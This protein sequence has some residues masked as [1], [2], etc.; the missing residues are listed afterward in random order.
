MTDKKIGVKNIEPTLF[1]AFM[2]LIF[3]IALL[4]I[5]VWIFGS[6]SLDGSNQMVLLFAASVAGIVALRIGVSWQRMQKKMVQSIGSAMPSII[7]LLLIGSLSGT[8]ILNQ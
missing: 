6:D 1:Q 8:W 3:L 2:P 7:I 4:F 5:N